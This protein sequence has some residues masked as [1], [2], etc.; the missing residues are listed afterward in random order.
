MT[1]ELHRGVSDLARNKIEFKDELNKI[2][3]DLKHVNDSVRE[4]Q[5]SLDI[6]KSVNTSPDPAFKMRI[7]ERKSS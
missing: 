5:K 7:R 1:L 6:K 2:S 4:A 3:K